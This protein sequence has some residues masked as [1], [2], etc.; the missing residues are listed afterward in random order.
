MLKIV[1][2]R[3]LVRAN[4]IMLEKMVQEHLAQGYELYG[5]PFYS[6]DSAIC[7]PMVKTALAD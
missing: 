2:Y 6:G 7:Q 3:L 1:D 4:H 5:A